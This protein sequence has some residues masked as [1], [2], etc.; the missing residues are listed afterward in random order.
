MRV[1]ERI[2]IREDIDMSMI[3]NK[4]ICENE[5]S[6]KKFYISGVFMEANIQNRNNRVYPKKVLEE[7]VSKFQGRIGNNQAMGELGHPDNLE[8]NLDNVSHLITELKFITENDCHGKAV[9][10]NTPKG[11]IAQALMAEGV[12]LGVSTRGSGSLKQNVVQNDYILRTVD[13]VAEPSAP[14]AFVDTI[15]ESHWIVEDGVLKE[16]NLVKVK[17]TLDTNSKRNLQEAVL[18]AFEEAM[19]LIGK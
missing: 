7:Q 2:L 11:K 16:E 3:E 9:I 1:M 15:L 6:P 17:K 10:L 13:I 12:R 4:I 18:F 19:S 8:I 5:N 14:N